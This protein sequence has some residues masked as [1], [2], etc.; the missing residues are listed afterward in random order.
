MGSAPVRVEWAR[1]PGGLETE[2]EAGEIDVGLGC[3]RV[4]IGQPPKAR[5]V[6][7]LDQVG[8]LVDE[9]RVEDPA[10]ND[11]EPVGDPYLAGVRAA[12]PP[13]ALLVRHPADRDRLDSAEVPVGERGG[14]DR[15][16]AIGSGDVRA[17]GQ[18]PADETLDE[19]HAV[20]SRKPG[21]EDD[22]DSSVLPE[23]ARRLAA[24]RAGSYFHGGTRGPPD[25]AALHA[26]IMT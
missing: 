6:G 5:R 15:E 17:L 25:P 22:Y 3:A 9:H 4:M 7:G 8:E 11:P 13:A 10:R 21:R 18:D 19:L 23:R 14:A 1:R 16:V 26:V 12:R 24:S 20:S 2:G